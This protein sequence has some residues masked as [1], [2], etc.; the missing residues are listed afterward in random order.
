MRR[1][2]QNPAWLGDDSTTRREA[3]ARDRTQRESPAAAAAEEAGEEA[4][5]EEAEDDPFATDFRRDEQNRRLN[6]DRSSTPTSLRS[7][8]ETDEAAGRDTIHDDLPADDF[9]SD[10]SPEGLG[11]EAQTRD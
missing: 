2:R 3:L 5:S 8:R 11:F 10:S 1:R 7:P 6:D 9:I 4:E